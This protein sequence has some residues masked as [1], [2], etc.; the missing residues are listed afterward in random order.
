[1]RTVRFSTE[2]NPEPTRMSVSLKSIE[3]D[4]EMH[5]HT[6]SNYQCTTH[7]LLVFTLIPSIF[8]SL[9]HD[10]IYF[11]HRIHCHVREQKAMMEA[12]D[13]EIDELPNVDYTM[14]DPDRSLKTDEV[15]HT[16]G[17]ESLQMV[18]GV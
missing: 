15:A 4:F 18:A 1:M 5:M 17:T 6:P 10:K 11:R 14:C 2:A 16:I 8:T 13:M 3:D 7:T 9:Q 12:V